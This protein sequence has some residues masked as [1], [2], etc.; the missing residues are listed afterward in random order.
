ME[1]F[2][3]IKNRRSIRT[4]LDKPVPEEKIKKI[5]EAAIQAPSAGNTQ[6]WRFVV[7]KNSKLK[8]QISEAALGQYFIAEAPIVIII[9]A[10]LKEIEMAY[11]KRGVELYS[12]LDC[13]VVAQN[14]M[15][16]ATAEGLATCPVGAFNEEEIKEILNLPENLRPVLIIPIGYPAEKGEEKSRKPL[17]E[18][19]WEV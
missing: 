12:L 16:A 18:I 10:D 15:L 17:S 11:G 7:I 8:N 2:E 13:G 14:L 1:I 19:T 6:E 9:C 5:L 3:A 4:F